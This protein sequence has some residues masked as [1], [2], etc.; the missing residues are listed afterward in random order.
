RERVLTG[1]IG[2]ASGLEPEAVTH[3]R[4]IRREAILL[5]GS[6]RLRSGLPVEPAGHECQD[7]ADDHWPGRR[8]VDYLY[9]GRRVAAAYP[10][11]NDALRRLR[12]SS[13]RRRG[14]TGWRS[15]LDRGP[16]RPV[17]CER[18]DAGP[19]VIVHGRSYRR[20]GCHR[21]LHVGPAI[22]RVFGQHAHDG[23]VHIS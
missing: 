17:P 5:L 4:R 23:G 2:F 10:A 12:W 22:L 8:L 14:R 15:E 6:S 19:N 3:R 7:S 9:L 11:L 1:E 21:V 18:N 16:V 20:N 13:S